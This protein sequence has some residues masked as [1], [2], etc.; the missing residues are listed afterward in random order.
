MGLTWLVVRYGVT[1]ADQ[2]RSGQVKSSQRK[3]VSRSRGFEWRVV[4]IMM[5]VLRKLT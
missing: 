1:I 5:V 3:T 4:I 2:I